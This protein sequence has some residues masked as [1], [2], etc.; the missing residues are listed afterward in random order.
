MWLF[1]GLRKKN[2]FETN[3]STGVKVTLCLEKIK[4]KSK[5]KKKYGKDA[6]IKMKLYS[7]SK[8]L[9]SFLIPDL[10]VVF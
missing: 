10:S 6:T 1:L 8:V 4:Y 2:T 5:I 3:S 9:V 7:F